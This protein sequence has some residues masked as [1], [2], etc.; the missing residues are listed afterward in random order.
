[1]SLTVAL[2]AEVIKNIE[3]KLDEAISL[4]PSPIN[5]RIRDFTLNTRGKMLRPFLVASTAKILSNN[6]PKAMELAYTSAVS[7]ELLHNFT[8]LHDDLI[9][10]APLRRGKKSYH[11]VHG[12]ERA[13]HDGDLLHAHA[14]N[15]VKHPQSLRLIV[16]VSEDVGRGNAYE[17]EDRLENVFDFTHERVIEVMKLKTAVVFSGSVQLGCIAAN[18]EHDVW[19]EKLK[20]AIIA[21]GIAFQIQDD[22]LDIL[23]DPS[24]F[25]KQHS[26]DIQESKRNLFLYYALKLDEHRERLMEIYTKPVGKK[27]EDEIN[28]VLQVFR[29]VAHNVAADKNKYYRHSISLINELD[30]E[31]TRDE[32]KRLYNFLKNLIKFL[33]ER[34][35]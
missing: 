15:L 18:R 26:W 16:E 9:D 5:E 22:Y 27:T 3:K 14:L 13:V 8:L 24:V 30:E 19:N 10:G 21:G 6:N 28:Y 33:C 32:V 23:G 20:E 31:E 1:M 2:D 11:I 29:E 25:G 12:L 17:L 34:E 7:V 35:K 4:L